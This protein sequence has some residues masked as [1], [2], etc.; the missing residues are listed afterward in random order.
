M[1]DFLANSFANFNSGEPELLIGKSI[2]NWDVFYEGKDGFNILNP[3][4]TWTGKALIVA[5]I[6]ADARTPTTQNLRLALNFHQWP[7]Q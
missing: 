3:C 5:G 2:G 6:Q 1:L 4:N 7:G